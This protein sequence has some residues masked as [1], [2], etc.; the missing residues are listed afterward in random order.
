MRHVTDVRAP[1][2]KIAAMARIR[3]HPR[4]IN[5]SKFLHLQQPGDENGDTPGRYRPARCGNP[6]PAGLTDDW[7]GLK[8]PARCESWP[9]GQR[10]GRAA[11]GEYK[12][13]SPD[14]DSLYISTIPTTQGRKQRSPK[15]DTAPHGVETRT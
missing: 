5:P 13:P 10:Q 4:I 7:L 12:V 14:D 2:Q 9:P 1:T 8:G 3:F 15:A 6:N 11:P